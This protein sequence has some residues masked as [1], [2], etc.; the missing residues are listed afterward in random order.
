[1]RLA[2][3]VVVALATAQSSRGQGYVCAEGGGCASCGYWSERVFGW[4]AEKGKFGDVV[5]LGIGGADVS[6]ERVFLEQGVASASSLAVN[7]SNADSAATYDAITSAEIVWIRG[8]DQYE[9]V[10]AWN[11]TLAEEAIR[12]VYDRGGVVGGSSAGLAVLS[13]VIYD[14][15]TGAATGRNLLRDAKSPYIHFTDDF[16]NLAQ[17]TLLDSHFTERGRL[18]RLPVLLATQFE[19]EGRDLVGIGVDYRTALCVYPDMTAEVR[20]EG[21]VTLLHRTER[22]AQILEP[23]SPPV[24]THLEYHQLI[25]GYWFDFTA[26][27]VFARPDHATLH[28]PQS[29]LPQFPEGTLS[30]DSWTDSKRG[31]LTVSDGGDPGALYYGSLQI[32]DGTNEFARTVIQ[33]KVWN[34]FEYDENR[35]GGLQLALAREPHL[36]GLYLDGGVRVETHPPARLVV[37]EATRPESATVVLDA[38]GAT[39]S[40]SSLF[41]VDPQSVGPRQSV[42]IESATLHLIREGW[43]YDAR[44]RRVYSPLG[45]ADLNA[46]CAIDLS[47]LG[48]MLVAFGVGAEGDVDGDADTD[49]SDLGALLAAFD[50][51]CL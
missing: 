15:G 9:Y 50:Q 39:S 49:L 6:L 33:T 22:T 20:G 24:I 4:M 36:L 7:K 11:G 14:A 44:V 13:D 34:S 1:M 40:A 38:Q 18:G 32:E 21:A 46:D 47:D 45:S 35:V 31:I 17:N 28:P 48:V 2:I 26:R 5:V 16:L 3:F 10:S 19:Q 8:G 30:G 27:E 41:I 43:E 29:E 23:Q 12:E 37:G 51:R 42:A 25:D